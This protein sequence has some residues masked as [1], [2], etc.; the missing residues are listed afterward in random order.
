MTERLKTRLF[1]LQE[2]ILDRFKL[3]LTA[4]DEVSEALHTPQ[5]FR[6]LLLSSIEESFALGLASGLL[7]SGSDE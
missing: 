5:E 3:W 6:R 4:P 7:T 1:N 2:N